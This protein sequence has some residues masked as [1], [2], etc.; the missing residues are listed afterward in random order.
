M[1]P[2]PEA[3]C[4]SKQDGVQ[5]ANPD[6]LPATW[7][8]R[9]GNTELFLDQNGRHDN[10]KMFSFKNLYDEQVS[11]NPLLSPSGELVVKLVRNIHPSNPSIIYRY[12]LIT[13]VW[14]T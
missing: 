4:L 10:S 9:Q 11:V 6:S 1:V 14:P 8:T 7:A 13:F 5:N 12:P 3:L 2:F